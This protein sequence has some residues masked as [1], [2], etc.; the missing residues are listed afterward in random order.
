[1]S[2]SGFG[3]TGPYRDFK[4][5][6]PIVQAVSGLTF[7]SGLPDSEPAGWGFSYMD[8][9]AALSMVIAVLAALHH[10]E[11][12]GEGQWVDLASTATGVSMLPTEVLDW[13]VNGRPSRRPGR[14]GGNRA[15]FDEMAPHV[16]YPVRWEDRWIA[17][18][19]RDDE[20]WKRLAACIDARWTD[21]DRFASLAGRID[22]QDE[23]DARLG[24]FTSDRDGARLAQTLR[25]AGVPASVV[26]S[27]PERIDE[28]PM[29]EAWGLFPE[30]DHPEIGRVRVEGLP[31]HLSDT[32]WSIDHAAPCLGEHTDV[33]L[34][35]VLGR[36]SEEIARLRAEGAV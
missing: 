16:I 9:G 2:N 36:S 29:P 20:E 7:T 23:L 30:V 35:E 26:S 33:V 10:R 28:D 21:D 18:A 27:P 14:P 13:S 4:T 31:I 3:H 32:D 15:D 1:M 6:G 8:H 22:A 25:D 19:C 11:Q 12:T 17:I 5:W 24:E 34:A